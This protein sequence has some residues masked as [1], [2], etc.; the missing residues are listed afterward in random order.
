MRLDCDEDIDSAMKILEL[1]KSNNIPFSLA[2]TTKLLENKTN[3]LILPKLVLE[4]NGN[5]LSVT[6]SSK[7][8]GESPE[9]IKKE[10][11]V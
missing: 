5:L 9:N 1:Y 4:N 7:D 11:T 3:I 6:Y 2:L 8:W 10:I